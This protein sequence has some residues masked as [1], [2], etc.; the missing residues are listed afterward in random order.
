MLLS[1]AVQK[2]REEIFPF[3]PPDEGKSF[4]MT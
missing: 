1:Q 2:K 3:A 4:R